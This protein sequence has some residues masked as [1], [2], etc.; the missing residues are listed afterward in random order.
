MPKQ[1][2]SVWSFRVLVF[3]STQTV[4]VHCCP[5]HGGHVLWA[6][7]SHWGWII[8]ASDLSFTLFLLQA[9]HDLVECHQEELGKAKEQVQLMEQELREREAEWKVTSAALKREAEERLARTLLDLTQRA[10]SGRQLLLSEFELRETEM[11]QLQDQQAAQIRDLEASLVEQQGRLGQLEMELAGDK[12][13][14]CGR[15]P[16]D[17]VAPAGEAWELAAARLKEDCALQ[18]TLAQNR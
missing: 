18:L 17:G 10:A 6:L 14:Q 2:V 5:R 9:K 8:A 4:A 1:V 12:C 16:G 13:P 15:E 11:R 7:P 3:Q